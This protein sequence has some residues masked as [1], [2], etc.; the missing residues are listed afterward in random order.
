MATAPDGVLRGA[1]VTEDV[2]VQREQTGEVCK[3]TLGRAQRVGG[4]PGRAVGQRDV[5]L[6]KTVGVRVGESQGVGLDPLGG[7]AV[8]EA[9]GHAREF[10]EAAAATAAAGDI[11]DGGGEDVDAQ[12][13]CGAGRGVAEVDVVRLG[14]GVAHGGE[15][16]QDGGVGGGDDAR[17]VALEGD[18]GVRGK[19]VGAGEEAGD[20]TEGEQEADGLDEQGGEEGEHCGAGRGGWAGGQ[21]GG[22]RVHGPQG[23]AGADPQN[24]ARL[25]GTCRT[26]SA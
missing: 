15:D 23:A 8:T 2:P 16:D 13:R 12:V 6:D 17:V 9:V 1:A 5:D 4:V 24:G 25:G 11:V 19:V 26:Q 10:A 14:G 21:A 22:E 18:G 20:R 7:V 3:D